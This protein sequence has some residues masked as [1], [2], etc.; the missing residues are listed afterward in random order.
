MGNPTV[1]VDLGQKIQSRLGQTTERNW[2]ERRKSDGLDLIGTQA[3]NLTTRFKL[4][5]RFGQT[6]E[7]AVKIY[8]IVLSGRRENLTVW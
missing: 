1:L 2:F 5:R 8:G 6:T 3:E 7:R 4:P